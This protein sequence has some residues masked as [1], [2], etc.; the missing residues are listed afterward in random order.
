MAE[1]K[2]FYYVQ[3]LWVKKPSA[4]DPMARPQGG[5]AFAAIDLTPV[6]FMEEM[7]Q[8]EGIDVMF[9][10]FAEISEEDYNRFKSLRDEHTIDDL[11]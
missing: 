6:A 2:K 1:K 8:N 7:K 3:Y 10:F 5:Q 11:P 9:N 4:L